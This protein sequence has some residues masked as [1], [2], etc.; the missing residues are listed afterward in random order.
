MNAQTETRPRIYCWINAG[1]GTDCVVSMAMAEDG[2]LLT[3][4][5]SSSD[6]F[7]KGDCGYLD[8]PMGQR[9]RK[10]FDA[11][12]PDGWEVEWVDDARNH[13]G[14]DAAYERNQQMAREAVSS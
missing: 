8:T 13:P 4:H 14:L 3:S 10:L 7:A 9:K 1:K 11:H 5:V 12:Y 6:G 2:T